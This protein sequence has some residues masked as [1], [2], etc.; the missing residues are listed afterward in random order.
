MDVRVV[1]QLYGFA[2]ENRA[3]AAHLDRA[4]TFARDHA[5]ICLVNSAFAVFQQKQRYVLVPPWK[6][7][8]SQM[9]PFLAACENYA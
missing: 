7:Y 1:A 2:H 8:V 3:I 4:L 9:C 6:D 5:A